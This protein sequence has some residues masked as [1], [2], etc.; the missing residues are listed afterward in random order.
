MLKV[1]M[2]KEILLTRFT[3]SRYQA[4]KLLL[5]STESRQFIPA[6]GLAPFSF[7]PFLREDSMVYTRMKKT[8]ARVRSK[9]DPTPTDK[10][11]VILHT[12]VHAETTWKEMV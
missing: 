3:I 12:S 8:Y 9:L 5:G 11:S 10:C 1:F 4:Q 2:V 7:T 6:R